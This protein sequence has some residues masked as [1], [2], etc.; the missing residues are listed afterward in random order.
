MELIIIL[1]IIGFGVYWFMSKKKA[2]ANYQ[3]ILSSNTDFNPTYFYPNAKAPKL[4][5]DPQSRS[6]YIHGDHPKIFH[7]SEVTNIALSD[8]TDSST[9]RLLGIRLAITVIDIEQPVRY[10]S[11]HGYGC[12][13]HAEQWFGRIQAVWNMRD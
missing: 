8:I 2:A 9:G 11:F 6:F 12:K 7:A 5:I 4:A 10:I 1:G 13:P 3:S